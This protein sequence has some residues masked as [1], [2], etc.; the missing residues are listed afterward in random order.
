[1]DQATQR[2]WDRASLGYDLM[3]G[4]GPE[5]RWAPI[6]QGL[7]SY[8]QGRI[9]FVA[10]GSGLDIPLFPPGREIIGADISE[11]MLERARPRAAAYQGKLDLVQAD[12]RAL[13]YED[14]AFDQ[15]FTACT[16]C[17][18]P[19]PVRGLQELRRVLRPGGELFMF[20]HTG[21]KHFPFNLMMHA[22]TPLSRRLGP[23]MNRDTVSNVRRAGFRVTEVVNTFLDVVK[24]IRA[25]NPG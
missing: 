21:S 3:V 19:D 25:V 18:V 8:M 22:M 11:K 15:V 1:M 14:D 7:F 24:T 12:V 5:R 13:S 9:F 2:K 23:D 6:K 4:G 10:I 16:F 17:S 20:E